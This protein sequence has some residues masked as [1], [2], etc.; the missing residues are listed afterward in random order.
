MIVNAV[1][2]LR[3][4]HDVAELDRVEAISVCAD[5]GHVLARSIGSMPVILGSL[6]RTLLGVPIRSRSQEAE[7]TRLKGFSVASYGFAPL[8]LRDRTAP[9]MPAVTPANLNA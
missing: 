7:M 8:V 5:T 1:T 4:V 6:D 9:H 2:G 3:I